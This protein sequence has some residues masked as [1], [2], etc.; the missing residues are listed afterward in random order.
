MRIT[1]SDLNTKDLATLVQRTITASDS[2]KYAVISNHPLLSELKTI[3]TEYD[4]V[5]T[6][7]TFSGKGN[8]VANADRDRDISFRALKNFLNGYRKMPSL[9]NYQFAE[10]LY[11]IFKLYDLS[12]DKMSYSSQ[13]AQMKKLI[14]DLE[15][16]ENIQKLNVLSLFPSFN[17]MKS[18]Q[19]TF[20][21]IFAEQAGANANLRNMKSASSIRKDLEK[22][23]RSYLN[24]ITVMKD[25]T[26]W[27]LLY[28]DINELVK[29]A[30]NSTA[31]DH[32]EKK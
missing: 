2:G 9:S 12:L 25:I 24:F 23:L 15:K 5:Y 4:A 11:Q 27:E 1:L 8:D 30:K 21:Q 7:S 16:P 18:K 22:A 26:G 14:E 10:D 19:D 6:K 13:T 3:Y 20:E 31:A 17:E 29:A 28:A 32:D